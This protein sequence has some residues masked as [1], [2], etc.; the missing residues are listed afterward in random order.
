MVNPLRRKSIFVTPCNLGAGSQ[1]GF[2][3][4][5]L[6]MCLW[7]DFFFP[8][9]GN[10]SD[11]SEKVSEE[12]GRRRHPIKPMCSERK[13]GEGLGL[14]WL[15]CVIF[16]DHKHAAS[17]WRTTALKISRDS[18]DVTWTVFSPSGF[19]NWFQHNIFEVCKHVH[20]R[21]ARSPPSDSPPVCR[22][23]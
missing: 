17:A 13:K 20:I 22:N 1:G 14:T 4:V 8:P 21:S 18:E 12:H 7:L 16:C 3:R 23:F 15:V 6:R 10:E 9:P 11:L 2:N 19:T 5:Q